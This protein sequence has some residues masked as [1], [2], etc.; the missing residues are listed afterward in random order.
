MGTVLGRK[1][2]KDALWVGYQQCGPCKKIYGNDV[3]PRN[4]GKSETRTDLGSSAA[5]QS[6]LLASLL[7]LP[8]VLPVSGERVLSSQVELCLS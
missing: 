2:V 1:K 5:E 8:V 4:P 3:T 7:C 6:L